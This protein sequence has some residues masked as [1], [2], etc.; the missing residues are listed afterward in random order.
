VNLFSAPIAFCVYE[1]ANR[2]RSTEVRALSGYLACVAGGI[3][4]GVSADKLCAFPMP[5]PRQARGQQRVSQ[6]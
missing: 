6:F 3:V 5:V 1:R 4:L 2:A